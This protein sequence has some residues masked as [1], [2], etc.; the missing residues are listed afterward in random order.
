MTAKPASAEIKAFIW[1]TD[2][3]C[4]YRMLR[5]EGWQVS[6]IDC[7]SFSYTAAAEDRLVIRIVN[8]QVMA[9]QMEGSIIAQYALFEQDSSLEGWTRAVEQNWSNLGIEF[10]SN[11]TLPQARIYLLEYAE[12]VELGALA[13]DQN[14]PLAVSLSAHGAYASQ[15]S[16]EE[17]GLRTDFLP[18][19]ESIQ[20]VTHDPGNMDPEID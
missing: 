3:A 9:R 7:R 2:G 8:Y 14:Q 18:M 16:L 17:A 1:Q 20:A 13:I 11:E 10:V 15:Q 4:G 19:L 12:H 5:P 6:K